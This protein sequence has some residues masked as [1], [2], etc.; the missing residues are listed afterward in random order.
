MNP[1]SLLSFNNTLLPHH[2]PAA[3]L[4]LAFYTRKT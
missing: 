1:D 3:T 2:Q 4:L